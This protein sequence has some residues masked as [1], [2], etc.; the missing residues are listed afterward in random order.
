M[1]Q[2]QHNPAAKTQVTF[3]W[4]AKGLERHCE[5]FPFQNQLLLRTFC[6]IE[7]TRIHVSW[8]DLDYEVITLL[9]IVGEVL[10]Q[11]RLKMRTH[12]ILISLVWLI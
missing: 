11:V 9:R 1:I 12:N 2:G 4:S 3:L 5:S 10:L 6:S 7:P 8:I